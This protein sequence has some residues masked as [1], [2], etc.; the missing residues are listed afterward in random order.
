MVKDLCFEI[1]EKC[2]NNCMFCSSDSN[3][4]KSQII[5]FADYTRVIDY[6]MNTGELRNYLYREENHFFTKIY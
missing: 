3:C 4:N 6:F 2:L 1:I 5:K